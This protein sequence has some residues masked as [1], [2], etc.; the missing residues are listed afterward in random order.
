[1]TQTLEEKVQRLTDIEDIKLLKL[2]YARYCDDNYNPDG[3]VSCFTDN[4][5]WDGGML[6]KAEGHAEIRE[7]FANAPKAVSFA[8]HYT[9]NPI[10]EI[11]GDEAD[12]TWYLW[13]PMVMVEDSQAMWL[14]AHY[15]EKYLR[16][17]GGW[18]ID[19]LEVKIKQF[20]PYETSFGQ[21]RIVT[22]EL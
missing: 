15:E 16:Q 19:R 22:P 4:G 5:V 2:R 8:T 11:N 21:V 3:I 1:M 17:N 6:G 13:Q 20:S 7:Y 18:L 9:T 12:G 10:I 14:G